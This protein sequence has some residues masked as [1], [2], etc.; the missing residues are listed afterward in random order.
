MRAIPMV[1]A[2]IL[3][4]LSGCANDIVSSPSSASA[5]PASDSAEY[6][7]TV[8]DKLQIGVFGEDRL[9]GSYIVASDGTIAFPLLSSVK[10]VG[11]TTDQI[12]ETLTRQLGAGYLTNPKVTVA[13]A[14]YLP[15]FVLGEVNSAGQYS[16]RPGM[17]V[18]AAIATAKGFTY[19][20]DKKHVLIQHRGA[21]AEE[22]YDLTPSL[23]LQPGDTIR[24]KERFF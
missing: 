17:T 21:A 11:L 12:R 18:L 13:M 14:E 22:L 24:L 10:V 5:A 7:V 20:A 9:T 15:F 1:V 4:C 3:L 16:Y 2:T 19:R 6:R 8:D 23:K